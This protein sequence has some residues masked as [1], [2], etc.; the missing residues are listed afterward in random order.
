VRFRVRLSIR[1]AELFGDTGVV[2]HNRGAAFS[3]DE[4][5]P[6]AL[7]PGKR[8]FFT[9]NPGMAL[10][11]EK[12]HILYGTQGAD[13]Q[14]QTLTALLTRL[15]DY[16]LD[17]LDALTRPRFLL[18]RTFS[19]GRDTLKLEASISGQ[20]IASLE[21]LGHQISLIPANSPL[22]GQAGAIV[23]GENGEVSGAHDPRSDGRAL[24][25]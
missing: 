25:L 24:G 12:P 18:G 14:P 2:W 17:P 13:G 5:S 22:G 10:K 16:G 6:N 21:E 15:I 3:I 4:G 20:T 7:R 9:L 23:I 19:D 11:H 1:E 8:P